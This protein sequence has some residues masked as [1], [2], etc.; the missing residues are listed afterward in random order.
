MLRQ[1]PLFVRRAAG[2]IVRERS[3]V[4]DREGKRAGQRS[5]EEKGSSLGDW[6]YPCM[7]A[8]VRAHTDTQGH[9]CR[10]R[11]T[12]RERQRVSERERERECV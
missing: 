1:V 4:G 8:D 7:H 9:T 12:H 2:Q 10:E 6:P 11:H 3:V 5:Q